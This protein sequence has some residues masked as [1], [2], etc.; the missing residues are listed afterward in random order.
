MKK[1]LA[2][3]L[4]SACAPVTAEDLYPG[5]SWREVTTAEMAA[6]KWSGADPGACAAPQIA[7]VSFEQYRAMSGS[8]S[9]ADPRVGT[10]ACSWACTM[11]TEAGDLIL[12]PPGKPLDEVLNHEMKHVWLGCTEGD[13]DARHL[14]PVWH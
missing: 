2:L 8:F 5:L 4:L 7:Q 14:S 13:H 12:W 1:V 9:C 10:G 6:V 11:Q 3:L